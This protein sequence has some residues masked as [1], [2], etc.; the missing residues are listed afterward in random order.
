M[1]TPPRFLMISPEYNLQR[2][3]GLGTHVQGLAPRLSERVLLDLIVPRYHGLGDLCEPLGAYGTV[4]RGDATKPEAGDDYDLQ[5]WR[6]NDQLNA[7]ITRHINN[8][9]RFAL[10]HAH[11]WLSG[12]VANDLRQRYHIPMVVTVHATEMGRRRGDVHGHP[13]RERIHLAEEYLVREADL[14]IACSEFMRQ[15]I[16]QSLQVPEENIRVIPNGVEYRHLIELRQKYQAYPHIRRRW[17]QPG[18]P[19]IFFVGRLEWEKGPDLLVQAMPKVLAE[20]PQARL[21]L[22]GKGSYT[23]QLITMVQEAGLEE[24]I[25]LA[26][27]ISDETRNELYAVADIAVFPSRYEPFGIVALETWYPLLPG[28]VANATTFDFPVRYKILRQATVERI[29]RADPALLDMI[30]QAGHELEQE[31]ARAMVGA[32]GYFANYQR[33]VAAALSI[34]VFLSSLLQVPMI[35]RA[36]KPDQQVGILVANAKTVRP[37]M[38]EACG[39][40]SDVPIVYLGMQDQP[41]FRNILEYGGQFHYDKFEAEVVDRARQLVAENPNVGAILLLPRWRMSPRKLAPWIW[42]LIIWC[43]C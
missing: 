11:D 21:V 24:A 26:G 42:N 30:V 39:I 8:G 22:A 5:V 13:L 25:Q 9:R 20:F 14:I 19:L 43:A 6:M 23:T 37:T 41:E 27:F 10:M 35:S 4:Y 3:G 15:E 34:P 40:T 18:Q 7:L 17:A 31:G 29:M 2:V 1:L 16:M 38:L 12:Y 32:C 28:N 36:L 33:Q